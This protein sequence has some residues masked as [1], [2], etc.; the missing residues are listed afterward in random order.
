MP[1]EKNASVARVFAGNDVRFLKNAYRPKRYIFEIS[2]GCGNK[3][4]HLW[5]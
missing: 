1:L 5:Q 3:I 2:N 4:K